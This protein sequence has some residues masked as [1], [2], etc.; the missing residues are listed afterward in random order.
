MGWFS[1]ALLYARTARHLRWEQWVYRPVRRIQRSFGRVPSPAG[2]VDPARWTRLREVVA[3]WGGGDPAA[4]VRRADE[5]VEG[6]FRFLNHTEILR[7]VDWAQRYVSHLWSYNL[8]YFDY[9][10]DLAWAARATGERR[11]VD[12]FVDLATSWIAACPPGKGDGWEP[13][14]VSLRI[15]NWIYALLLLGDR[16]D[17]ADWERIGASVA[18]QTAYLERRLEFHIL[19]NHLLKNLKALVIAGLFFS[20]R[21]AERW[22]RRGLRLLWRELFEQ[23][24]RDGVH[25]ERSPMYHAIALADFL[26]VVALLDAVGEPVPEDAR[27]RVGRMVEALGVLSRPDGSLHRFNDAADGI[28]PSRGWLDGMARAIVGRAVPAP[29]GAIELRDAG[30]YAYVDP[31]TGTRLVVDCGEPGPRYQPGHAHCDLLSFELDLAGRRFAVDSGVAGYADHPL[32]EYVRSTRAHNT[33]V[34]AGREQSEIWGAFR[35]ARRARVLGATVGTEASGG[36]GWHGRAVEG[37]GRGAYRVS[38]AYIPYFDRRCVHERTIEGAGGEWRV[39]D[40]VH[41]ADG[42]ALES[43]LHLHPDWTLEPTEGGLAARAGG[44]VVVIEPFGVD[45]VD[46]CAGRMDP[47]QGWYCPEFGVAVPAPAIRM[48]VE[49]NDG[50]PFGYRV[51]VV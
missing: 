9:A 13:Y 12:R 4:R 48:R 27:A 3:D 42:A 33:V 14:P 21:D 19:A 16:V 29:T 34:I 28:A 41:G 30:Y 26:E 46:W 44:D 51:R 15:V 47:P 35:M 11:F 50:R 36:G 20:G 49:R 8:H 37:R 10:L 17:A 5:I 32:R 24:L 40:R 22:L 1:R 23:V 43:W 7:E 39:E 31:A 38:G 18:V 45:A 6:V 2:W 25:Y